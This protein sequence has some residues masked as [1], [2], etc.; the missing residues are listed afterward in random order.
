V[1]DEAH[2]LED[3]ATS[4]GSTRVSALA[5]RRAVAPLLRHRERPG[6]LERLAADWA[7]VLS[8]LAEPVRARLLDAVA[9]AGRLAEAAAGEAPD[10]LAAAAVAAG[11]EDQALPVDADPPPAGPDPDEAPPEPPP[12]A[13]EAP[14]AGL[15]DRLAGAARAL[16]AVEA[17]LEGQDVPPRAVQPLLD[18][19]RARLRLGGHATAARAFLARDPEWC[20]W[21]EPEARSAQAALCRAPVDVGPFLAG[22]VYRPTRTLVLTSATLAVRGSFDHLLDRVGLAP[23]LEASGAQPAVAR[24]WPSPFRFEEQA[25]LGLPRDL[26]VPGDPAWEDAVSA[27]LVRALGISGGGAFVLCT[28]FQALHA[29]ADR[30]EDALGHRM[31]VLRQEAGGRTRLLARFRDDPD[32]VLFGTDS[33]WEG[34]DVKGDAL[35]LVA[36]PRL[37]F[38]VPTEPV[39]RARHARLAAR[40]VD[41]FRALSLPDA[42]LKLRQGF[43]RLIRSATD[44]GAVLVLD[45]RIHDRWYGRLFLASLPPARRAV[46]PGRAVLAALEAFYARTRT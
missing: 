10:L 3:A 4:A 27:F 40:G 15:A 43:G 32:S 34:V 12:A 24:A 1:L 5:V 29:L 35:R 44:R 21:L 46:G 42:V 22:A 28:S 11:L 36:I 23:W 13:W 37:P 18:L 8:P 7:G 20:R 17:C 6:A 19:R 2:H 45:R 38:G 14:V 41:P 16:G 39:T 31:A 9:E 30:A 26:P 25:L 33:F